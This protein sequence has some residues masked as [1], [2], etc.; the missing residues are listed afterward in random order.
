MAAGAAAA[1][2]PY[3]LRLRDA[4]AQALP[5]GVS[6]DPAPFTIGVAS[7]DPAGDSVVLWTRVVDE[8]LLEDAQEQ[9]PEQVEVS[10]AIATDPRMRR[11]VKSGT[12]IAHRGR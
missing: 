1:W 4:E 2:S 11:V 6:F 3:G 5:L 7:G 10:W 12:T 9:M 8:P